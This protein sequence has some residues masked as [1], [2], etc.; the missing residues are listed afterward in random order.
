MTGTGKFSEICPQ[1]PKV[2]MA[3]LVA[4][5][6]PICLIAS[7]PS[8]MGYLEGLLSPTRSTPP[9][10][11]CST[12]STRLFM[13]YPHESRATYR[14]MTGTLLHLKNKHPLTARRVASEGLTKT[15]RTSHHPVCLIVHGIQYRC[16]YRKCQ[17]IGD[18]RRSTTRASTQ[19]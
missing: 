8:Y 4:A 19:P 14:S 6:S 5:R 3:P 13:N 2:M 12:D 1:A 17:S 16:N 7:P 9:A 15:S 10:G 11:P 18:A